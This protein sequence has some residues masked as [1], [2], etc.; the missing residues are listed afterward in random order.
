[1]S[2]DLI[3]IVLPVSNQAD[4]I[5]IFVQK[6]EEALAKIQNPHELILVVNACHD[7]T[8]EVCYAL[9]ERYDPVRVVYSKKGG[10][11]LAVKIGLA[12]A[13]GKF[14]CYTNSARTSPED[15]IL[16]LLYAVVYPNVVIKANRKIRDSWYR[17]LGSLLFNL[18]CRVFLDLPTWDINGTP[19]VFPCQFNKLL[20]LTRDD[21]L[22]DA[23][24]NIVCRREGY[25]V[26]EV[27]IFYSQRHGGRS[28]TNYVSA[29]RMYW[30]AFQ[31]S[32][33]LRKAGR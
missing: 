21:D 5:G 11:G 31:L 20:S 18:E 22:L 17:W 13:K 1:M 15:L 29:L 19:K 7:C 8:L 12:E 3:S 30:G 6:Y 16:I 10:W 25:P 23:E 4:H 9:A 14:L 24:F 28:T 33:N 32:R 26:K 2:A 27:P